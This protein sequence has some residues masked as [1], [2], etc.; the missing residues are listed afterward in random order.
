MEFCSTIVGGW[1]FDLGLLPALRDLRSDTDMSNPTTELVS[2][3]AGP[4]LILATALVAG[5]IFGG[6]AKKIRLPGITGQILVGGLLGHAGLEVFDA[7]SLEG[8]QPLTHFALGL[9][10]VTVG[11]H[12]NIRRLRNAGKRLLLLLL[13]ESLV[14]PAMVFGGLILFPE[15]NWSMAL[16][17]GTL[18]ISTAP[19]TILALVKETRSKGVFVKTLIAAVALN[20]VACIL[21]FEIARLAARESV[22][23]PNATS[24]VDI[25]SGALFQ[26]F[27][28]AL[29]G[30]G[31]AMAI[32]V[33][34]RIVPR[35][36]KQTTAG[37]IA[38]LLTIGAANYLGFS[39]ML[40]CLFMGFAEANVNRDRN[41]VDRLFSDFEPAILTIFFTLAGMELSLEH[42][43][44]AG[45]IAVVFFA[46][47]LAGKLIAANVAMG[48]AGATKRVQRNLGFALVPQA[49]VAVGLVLLLENDPVLS[50]ERGDLVSLFVAAVLTT[51][52][53]NEVVG[54]ILTRMALMRSG[55]AGRDRLRLIDFIH[56][57]NIVTDMVA[58]S[59][60][61]AIR[62]LTGIMIQT[63]HLDPK[64]RD[65][66]LSS[67]LER[68][69]EMSTCLGGG[70]A[71][72]HGILPDG[73]NMVGVMGISRGGFM[74]DTPDG[75]PV[76]C[77]VLLATPTHAR[78]RHLQ[79]L[80]ALSRTLG[81]DPLVQRALFNAKSPAHAYE[82]LHD[83]RA[84]DFN[85]FIDEKSGE[86]EVGKV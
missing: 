63:H 31:A 29:T 80:A 43:A 64:I 34:N 73:E 26:L 83:E 79:V 3:T 5:S 16:L 75:K 55:E 42:A 4:L 44:K 2:Q 77:I 38:I 54:P 70:L 82:I 6:L 56:E 78:E 8:L 41:S 49:G 30:I 66:L 61:E 1:G 13:V 50:A 22:A 45:L 86:V 68:E 53:A 57:E 9:M 51:V 52:V 36:E 27:A 58:S 71:V 11:T 14:I 67:A 84:E 59:P 81:Q 69:K 46:M 62:V 23:N 20:N 37:F 74:F 10:A 28:A 32:L 15:V 40:A 48:L 72:P 18:A 19:A 60:E 39:A 17:F 76:H 25:G 21:L 12:L 35:S 47:R 33:F 85:Y 7:E 65:S 24:F